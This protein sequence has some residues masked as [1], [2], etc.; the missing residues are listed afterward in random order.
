MRGERMQ[1]FLK[2]LTDKSITLEV[3]PTDTIDNLKQLIYE[4]EGIPPE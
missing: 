4:K 1:I 3:D 2:W